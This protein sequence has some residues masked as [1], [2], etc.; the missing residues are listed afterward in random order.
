MP[1][2]GRSYAICIDA[3]TI[4]RGDPPATDARKPM[5]LLHRA[6]DQSYETAK[7]I[8]EGDRRS[9]LSVS[10]PQIEITTFPN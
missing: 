2:L 1:S 8:R 4:Q 3:T 6:I 10:A 7:I 5:Q 9:V